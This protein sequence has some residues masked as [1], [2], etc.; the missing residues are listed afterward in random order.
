M[1][2][3]RRRP[4]SATAIATAL[5]RQKVFLFFGVLLGECLYLS[6]YVCK[7]C[8]WYVLLGLGDWML[9]PSPMMYLPIY[10]LSESVCWMFFF[11]LQF[12]RLSVTIGKKSGM[13]TWSKFRELLLTI[14]FRFGSF[15]EGKWDKRSQVS[16]RIVNNHYSASLTWWICRLLMRSHYQICCIKSSLYWSIFYQDLYWMVIQIYKY[17]ARYTNNLSNNISLI[18]VVLHQPLFRSF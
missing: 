17:R 9:S 15:R 18:V 2:V 4:A 6:M 3:R 1:Y 11:V 8:F 10:H 14:I 7:M 12:W 13:Q 5:D 16:S